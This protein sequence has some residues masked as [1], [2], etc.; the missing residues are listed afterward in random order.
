ML[1]K[2]PCHE[3]PPWSPRHVFCFYNKKIH[4]KIKTNIIHLKLYFLY[5]Q[6]QYITKFFCR[7]H[8]LVHL[9]IS[10]CWLGFAQIRCT[11]LLSFIILRLYDFIYKLYNQTLI[12]I[13]LIKYSFFLSNA[14]GTRSLARFYKN[15]HSTFIT[16]LCCLLYFLTTHWT[17]IR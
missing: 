17:S 9:A 1:W 3:H 4:D 2:G 16:L 6:N 7:H 8:L 11:D 5:F 13:S 12:F 15:R 10:L 14:I